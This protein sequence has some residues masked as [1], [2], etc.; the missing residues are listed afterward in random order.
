MASKVAP[1]VMSYP[2]TFFFEIEINAQ[3]KSMCQAH[4]KSKL[5][6]TYGNCPAFSVHMKWSKR[7]VQHIPQNFQSAEV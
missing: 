4:F 3:L 1:R 7:Y 2:I 5:A 6:H